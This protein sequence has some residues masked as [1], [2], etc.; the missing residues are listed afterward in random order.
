MDQLDAQHRAGS[1]QPRVDER[2]AVIDIDAFRDAADG[3]GRAQRGSQPHD[4]LVERPPGAHHRPGVIID[5]AE[6]V[7][8]AAADD[9][10]V[11]RVAG[12]QLVGPGGLEPAEDLLLPRISRRGVQL[13]AAEQPLQ[14]AVR[15]R[16]ARG[17][18]QD[19][20][21]LRGGALGVLPFQRRRQVQHLGRGARAN[22]PRGRDQRLEPAGQVIP[23]PP[24]DRLIRHPDFGAVRS[25][26]RHGGK[27]PHPPAPL[28][29]RQVRADDVLDQ[30]V[31]EQ[32]D[33]PRPLQPPP[34]IRF[35]C[36][37]HLRPFS[38]VP[39][40]TGPVEGDSQQLRLTRG[41]SR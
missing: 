40:D 16:P 32:R 8:L 7:G 18:P 19:P 33:L 23:L 38:A 12:P 26:M 3:Q 41:N 22:L 21:D 15:R 6:Q 37:C 39:A 31:P 9:R 4:I 5:E 1:Q 13:Q 29:G 35:L 27:L 36:S 20:L 24:V 30:R 28:R 25:G 2:A 11:Q 14:G 10:A 34:L 17:G